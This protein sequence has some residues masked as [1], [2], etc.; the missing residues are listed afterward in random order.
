MDEFNVGTVSDSNAAT[1][2]V[3]E[4]AIVG[5]TVGITAAASDADATHQHSHPIR[6]RTT[7]AAGS[8]SNRVP[9]SSRSPE[10]STREADGPSR[11]ITVRATSADGSFTDQVF[12][13][14]INDV[15]EFNVGAVTDT[16]VTV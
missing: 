7:T 11:N 8:Q 14:N 12:A 1:N 9:G 5:T 10:R 4:N 13:I 6:C 16:D 2:E 15:D 3:D